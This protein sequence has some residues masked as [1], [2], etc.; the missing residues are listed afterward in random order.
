M[1]KRK[2]CPNLP[3]WKICPL[4]GGQF[5]CLQAWRK[6]AP[7]PRLHSGVREGGN[8]KESGDV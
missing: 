4:C 7:D 2:L 1:A 8:T 6:K 5:A 3:K